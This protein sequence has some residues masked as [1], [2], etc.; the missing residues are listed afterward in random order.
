[1]FEEIFSQLWDD[2]Y[3]R[4]MDFANFSATLEAFRI[5]ILYGIE[6]L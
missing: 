6:D 1:M 5:I 4:Y 2:K 3:E